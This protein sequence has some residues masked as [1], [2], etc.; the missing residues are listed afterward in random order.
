MKIIKLIQNET[1]KTMKKTSTK[2][3]ILLAILALL[4]AVGFAKGITALSNYSMSFINDETEWKTE[5][6]NRLNYLKESI[7]DKNSY[8]ANSLAQTKALIEVLELALENNINYDYSYNY[9]YWKRQ[10]LDE[11]MAYRTSVILAE[12]NKYM[13]KEQKAEKEKFQ[14]QAEERINI[15]KND[16]YAGYIELLKREEKTKLDDKEIEKD[17]YEDNIYLLDLKAKYEIFKN[18][19]REYE[20]KQTIYSDIEMIKESLRTGLNSNTGKLLKPSE[21]KNMED[22]LKIDEY[23]LKNDITAVESLTDERSLYDTVSEQFSMLMISLL[24][25]II[26]GSAISTEISKGTIKFLL[27]TPNK[28]WKVLLAKIISAIIILLVLTV[29]LSL[30]SV[31]IGNIFFEKPGNDYIYVK[32]G[33]VKTLSYTVYMVLYFLASSIDILVYMF[34]A[35]MLSVITRNT[36]LAVGL[37]VAS[38]VGSGIVM[39]LIN[40]YIKADWVKFIPFNNFGIA[41]KIFASSVSYSTMQIASEAMNNVSI[42]FSLGVL[43]VSSLLMIITMFDSFNKRDIV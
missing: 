42:W 12:N 23:K 40:M 43:G 29:I 1:I 19:G 11:V 32:D 2:I 7:E 30:L 31:L 39:N 27:F 28:R 36:A 20:S 37:S 3:L 26:A 5:M 14:N 9:Y 18:D 24:M 4:G 6:Q 41:D 33:E 35:F 21:Y 34:F 13:S 22:A 8:N 38:Y 10:L 16:D 25:I 17:E 15:I